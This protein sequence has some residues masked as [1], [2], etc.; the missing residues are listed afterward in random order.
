MAEWLA[1][2]LQPLPHPA[3]RA[4]MQ[5]KCTND[6]RHARTTG[7]ADGADRQGGNKS[8]PAAAVVEANGERGR[9]CSY[10]VYSQGKRT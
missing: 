5:G 4:T 10:Q 6:R 9:T 7:L 3:K 8:S 2:M 1:E